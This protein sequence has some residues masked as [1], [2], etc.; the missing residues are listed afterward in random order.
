M[1]LGVLNLFA[2]VTAAMPR[3]T[4]LYG[5]IMPKIKSGGCQLGAFNDRYQELP[6]VVHLPAPMA[7]TKT[8]A[9]PTM[10]AIL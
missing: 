10:P 4:K 5:Q 3:M 7:Y 1:V 2:T 8:K 6:V 9:I